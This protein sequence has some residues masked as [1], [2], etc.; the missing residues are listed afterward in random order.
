MRKV[1]VERG[2]LD[3]AQA[4]E[5]SDREVLDLIFLPGFSTSTQVS[6]ISGRGVGMDVV[7][8]NVQRLGGSVE[9]ESEPGTGTTFIDHAA[10]HAR[11]H[12]RAGVRACAAARWRCRSRSCRRW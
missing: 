11:D 10:D 9:V 12:R 1:A 2:L 3:R 8:T 6:D 5:L 7:H 4:D